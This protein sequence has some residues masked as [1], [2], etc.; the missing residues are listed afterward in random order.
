[1]LKNYYKTLKKN[2]FENKNKSY[3]KYPYLLGD[4]AIFL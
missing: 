2:I 1:M 4:T 3:A